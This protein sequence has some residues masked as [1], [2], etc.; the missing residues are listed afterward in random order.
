MDMEPY[1]TPNALGALHDPNLCITDPV[2]VAKPLR[3]MPGPMVL[4]SYLTRR[5]LGL[6]GRE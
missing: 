4:S 6:R 2:K 1:I 3:R 5:S